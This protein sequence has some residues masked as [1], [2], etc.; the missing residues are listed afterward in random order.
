MPLWRPPNPVRYV[1]RSDDRLAQCIIIFTDPA[2]WRSFQSS[3]GHLCFL[4]WWTPQGRRCGLIF[5]QIWSCTSIIDSKITLKFHF[6]KMA[7][8]CFLDTHLLRMFLWNL[9]CGQSYRD[10]F[11]ENSLKW[12][13]CLP[14]LIFVCVLAS[15]YKGTFSLEFINSEII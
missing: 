9:I 4:L 12:A 7:D 1:G 14:T 11:E 15:I 8:G 6:K 3:H 10:K 5:Y 2:Q 13:C